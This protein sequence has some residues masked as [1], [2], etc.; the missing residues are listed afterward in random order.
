MRRVVIKPS[1]FAV[2]AGVAALIAGTAAVSA[3]QIALGNDLKSGFGSVAV[4]TQQNP[5]AQQ[6]VNRGAKS[7]RLTMATSISPSA[8]MTFKVPGLANTLIV[9]RIPTAAARPITP[10]NGPASSA[11]QPV[12]CEPPVSVL[13]DIAKFIGPSHCVT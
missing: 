7:D 13:T 9:T 5:I 3:T 1:K 11:R 6:D 2:F 4:S 8:T 12:A 10:S